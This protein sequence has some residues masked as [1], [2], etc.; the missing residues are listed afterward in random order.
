MGTSTEALLEEKVVASIS[1]SAFACVVS[2]FPPFVY[3][4]KGFRSPMLPAKGW[5]CLNVFCYEKS[6]CV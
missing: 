1:V 4:Y 2:N 6:D 3:L 5:S